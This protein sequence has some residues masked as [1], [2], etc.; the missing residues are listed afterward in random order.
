MPQ[1]VLWRRKD[2]LSDGVSGAKTWATY[3]GEFVDNII[4]DETFEEVKARFPSKEAVYYYNVYQ[5]YFSTL[6][7]NMPHYWLPKWMGDVTDPSGRL[8]EECKDWKNNNNNNSAEGIAGVT[9]D[10]PAASAH[11][12]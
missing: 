3:I 2:G 4:S 1:S 9:L 7:T 10:A 8:V 5:Q 11:T 6:T 12:G